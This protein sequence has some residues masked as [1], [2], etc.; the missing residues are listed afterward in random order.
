MFQI[1]FLKDFPYLVILTSPCVID[2]SDFLKFGDSFK[3]LLQEFSSILTL[4]DYYFDWK[5]ILAKL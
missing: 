3:S 1:N 5:E 2:D 4:V